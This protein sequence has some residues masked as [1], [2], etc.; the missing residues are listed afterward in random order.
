[1]NQQGYSYLLREQPTLL[2]I[3]FISVFSSNL[4]QSFFIGLFQSDISIALGLSAGEFGTAYSAVTLISAGALI[5]FGPKVDWIA[6]RR[7]VL[8]VLIGIVCGVLILT[9]T[10]LLWLGLI[11]LCLVRLNGQ[12]MFTHFGNTFTGRE[13]KRSRGRALSLISLGVPAGEIILPLF[14]TALLMS[15]SWQQVWWVLAG[16]WCSVWAL[17]LLFLPWPSSALKSAKEHRLEGPKPLRDSQF[18]R[19]LP[20]MM[21][22]PIIMTGIMIYQAQLTKDLG[23]SLSAYAIALTAMGVARIVG[24][25]FIGPRIDKFGARSAARMYILP[26]AFALLMAPVVEGSA[27]L[28]L[29][30]MFG[31]LTFGFQESVIN[32]LLVNIWGT[33]YLGKVLATLQASMVLSTGIAPAVL[34]YLI[35]FDVHFESILLGMFAYLVIAW[36]LA[37]TVLLREVG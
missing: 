27:G 6:P 29:L 35:E 25:L 14:V 5:Y 22:L 13:F 23:A 11:G 34:G 20:L 32:S 17:V 18:L 24:G 16:I 2:L 7:F 1:M 33:E 8:S 15:L 21:A 19:L 10:D 26:F 36:V 12:G 4:G 37:Q 9:T 30:M 3:G 31:G 28:V